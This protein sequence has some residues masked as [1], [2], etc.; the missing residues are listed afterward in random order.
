MVTS[1]D[2]SDQ[3]PELILASYNRAT[4]ENSTDPNGLVLLWNTKLQKTTPEYILQAQ[5]S[6]VLVGRFPTSVENP[7]AEL[8]CHMGCMLPMCSRSFLEQY[9]SPTRGVLGGGG[10]VTHLTVISPLLEN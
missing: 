10:A 8:P 3:H 2:W 4:E 5:V 9:G 7:L 6:T 1:M